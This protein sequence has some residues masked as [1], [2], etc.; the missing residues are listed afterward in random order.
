MRKFLILFNPQAGSGRSKTFLPLIEAYLTHVKTRYHLHL[1]TSPGDAQLMTENSDLTEYSGVIAAGGDGTL[2]EVINGL[3]NRPADQR[4]PFGVIPVGTGNAF[5]R[6]LGLNPTDWQKGIDIILN[7]HQRMIDVGFVHATSC[8]FYFINII[9]MGFVVD[10]GKSTMKIKKI[11]QSAYT[12]ATL[13]ETAK[14]KK[15]PVK[16]TLTDSQNQIEVI[17][18][19]LVFVE[20]ANSRY[21]GTSFLMAPDAVIDDGLLNVIILKKI[22][23]LKILRL[24]PTIYS[25]NHVNYKEVETRK[26][27]SVTIETKQA[28]PLMPDGEFLGET[29]VTIK[30]MNHA[31]SI[32]H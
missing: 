3:M 20:V 11:G 8:D 21:T 13:W 22:S 5:S 14:L 25:G 24:F 15:H 2:F 9:G 31:L 18:E 26:V 16:L 27:K 17:S 29:P 19:E 7:N 10:A 12:L 23:R 6:E 4:I 30:C 1:T 28:M 32:F